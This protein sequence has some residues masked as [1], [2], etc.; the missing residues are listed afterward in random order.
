MLTPSNLVPTCSSTCQTGSNQQIIIMLQETGNVK[1]ENDVLRGQLADI[2][3]S[4]AHLTAANHANVQDAE[5][6][7]QRPSAVVARL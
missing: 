5:V 2:Q 7:N 4:L 1:E 6:C 3:A